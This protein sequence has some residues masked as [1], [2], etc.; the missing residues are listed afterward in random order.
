ME[1]LVRDSRVENLHAA[2][3]VADCCKH[4]LHRGDIEQRLAAE[5]RRRFEQAQLELLIGQ[6]APTLEALHF[7][8]PDAGL[9][10]REPVELAEEY[11]LAEGELIGVKEAASPVR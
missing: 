8:R 7:H 2:N 4:R 6:L 5:E 11:R 9:L 1:H 10:Q 3:A